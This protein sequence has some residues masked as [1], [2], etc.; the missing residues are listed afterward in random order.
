MLGNGVCHS[1]REQTQ[2]QFLMPAKTK[3]LRSAR[4]PW[5]AWPPQCSPARR[6]T[7]KTQ[8]LFDNSVSFHSPDRLRLRSGDLL[9]V[10]GHCAYFRAAPR[11]LHRLGYVQVL[12]FIFLKIGTGDQSRALTLALLARTLLDWVIC[13]TLLSLLFL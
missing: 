12:Y 3:G 5:S 2:V 9:V 13:P 1:N 11:A 6:E 8:L 10:G 7:H 4:S